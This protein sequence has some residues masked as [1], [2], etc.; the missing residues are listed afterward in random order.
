MMVLF[1]YTRN[2]VSVFYMMYSLKLF[3][4]GDGNK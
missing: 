3:W 1:K 4:L 2:F